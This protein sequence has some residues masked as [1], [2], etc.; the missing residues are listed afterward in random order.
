VRS[1]RH[2]PHPG[3]EHQP[4]RRAQGRKCP[5]GYRIGASDGGPGKWAEINRKD[6]K[7]NRYEKQVTGAPNNIEWHV[8]DAEMAKKIDEILKNSNN[9]LPENNQGIIKVIHTPDIVN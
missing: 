5:S 7:A 6:T 9:G 1:L 2:R 4:S 3:A 8:S